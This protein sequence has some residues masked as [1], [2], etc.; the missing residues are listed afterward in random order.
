VPAP[1]LSAQTFAVG[2]G[3]VHWR[4]ARW[5][6]AHEHNN[7]SGLLKVMKAEPFDAFAVHP[8]RL[9]VYQL[10]NKGTARKLLKAWPVASS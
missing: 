2:F 3:A 10:G 9:A 4:S 6:A 5:Q 1:G 7:P 8:T